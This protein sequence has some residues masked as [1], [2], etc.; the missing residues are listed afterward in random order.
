MLTKFPELQGIVEFCGDLIRRRDR[1]LIE[2][3]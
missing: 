2:Y 3:K 1:A